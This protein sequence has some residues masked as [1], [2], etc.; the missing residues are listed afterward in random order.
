MLN[1][2]C[3]NTGP[4]PHK[5]CS[6]C[7][8]GLPVDSFYVYKNGRLSSRCKPC[9]R[10]KVSQWSKANR[11]RKKGN[12]DRY[13]SKPESRQKAVEYSSDY[14]KVR[15]HKKTHYNRLRK[16]RKDNQT[17]SWLTKQNKER[18]E[19]YYEL[20]RD[21][22][23]ITGQDYHVDHIIPL[24]GKNVCG[25]HVPWNLQVL[26]ADLNISKSNKV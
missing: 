3:E 16:S 5:T 17:P 1:F 24:N 23:V 2:D 18:I 15:R 12:T 19:C 6:T 14:Y 11:E 26:P 13:R 10:Q 25:L 4:I 8:A 22:R 9:S 20:A 7:G 21:L